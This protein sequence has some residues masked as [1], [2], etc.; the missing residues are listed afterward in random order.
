MPDSTE[1]QLARIDERVRSIQAMLQAMVL[2]RKDH[3]VRIQKLETR[4][5][6]M[7]GAAA[8]LTAAVSYL[9]NKH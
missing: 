9:F 8:V 6:Y 1:T 7:L 3:V 2:E 5:S 4:H